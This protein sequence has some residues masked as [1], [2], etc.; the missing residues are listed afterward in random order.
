MFQHFYFLTTNTNAI[1]KLLLASKFYYIS[2]SGVNN[3][4]GYFG[5]LIATEA[6]ILIEGHRQALGKESLMES[7]RGETY[8]EIAIFLFL[9]YFRI[10]TNTSTPPNRQ[11]Y[12]TDNSTLIK[13]LQQDT[14]SKPYPNQY[15]LTNYNVHT[16]ILNLIKQSAGKLS[17]QHLKGHQDKR[18]SKEQMISWVA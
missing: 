17:F 9:Y 12:Y 8:G 14:K 4:I 11:Y 7:L 10:Y 6:N 15:T 2:D 18:K 3:G 13:R 1:A 16:T 5:W